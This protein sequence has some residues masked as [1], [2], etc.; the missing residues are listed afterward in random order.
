MGIELVKTT[1]QGVF[2]IKPF[3]HEDDR[4]SFTK[5]VSRGALEPHNLAYS[6][7]ESYES[8][9]KKNV[10]RG[11]H[12]QVPPFD[13]EKIVCVT[14]GAIRDVVLDLR[15]GSPTYGHTFDQVLDDKTKLGIYIPKGC[16]HGFCALED[17]ARVLYHQTTSHA[18]NYDKGILWSSFGF[19]W[20]V[21]NP[22]LSERDQGFPPLSDFISPFNT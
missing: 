8:S 13:H 15:I 18:P 2:L 16:A 5:Y 20:P 7:E 12:F 17:G 19:D 14:K 1:L 21:N 4:G 6:F 22:V 3:H 10:V 9:S 11:M